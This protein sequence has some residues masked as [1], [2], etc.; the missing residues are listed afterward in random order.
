VLEYGWRMAYG[1]DGT[2][3]VG[4]RRDQAG[5]VGILGQIPKR[6]VSAGKEDRVKARGI[7]G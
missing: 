3:A 4:E 7:D 6:A 5:A 1:T 2:V